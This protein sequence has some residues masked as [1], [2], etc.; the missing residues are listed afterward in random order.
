MQDLDDDL[1][2]DLTP[3]IDVIFMLVIFFIMTMSFTLPVVDF[4]LPASRTAQQASQVASMRITINAQGTFSVEQQTMSYAQ[5]EQY[6]KE[7]VKLSQ[8][9]L[10]FEVLIDAN[11]PTQY[12][13]QI[14]DLSRLYAQGRLA[15]I[16]TKQ[17]DPALGG[18]LPEKTQ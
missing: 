1:H 10:S 12:L 18:M 8:Q 15:I 3:L 9:A 17:E 16:T 4:N 5:L 7:Q 2:V 11:T 6:L 14:A 13:I